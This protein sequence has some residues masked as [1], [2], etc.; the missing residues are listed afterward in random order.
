MLEPVQ[1]NEV[2]CGTPEQGTQRIKVLP[3]HFTEV[4][5]G[6]LRKLTSMNPRPRRPNHAQHLTLRFG[7]GF[8]N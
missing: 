4:V 3:E 6:E 2:V 7:T 1:R 8:T 5:E